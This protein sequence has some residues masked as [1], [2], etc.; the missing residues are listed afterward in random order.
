MVQFPQQPVPQVPQ[1]G[2]SAPP[3]LPTH[4]P[5][6]ANIIMQAAALRQ[7]RDLARQRMTQDNVKTMLEAIQTHQ[8]LQEKQRESIAQ[9]NI[10]QATLGMA[11]AKLEPEKALM[12]AQTEHL[13]AQSKYQKS[14][15]A[16]MN[17]NTTARQLFAL[18]QPGPNGEPPKMSLEQFAALAPRGVQKMQW[19][20]AAAQGGQQPGA[21]M[22]AGTAALAGKKTAAQYQEGAA[23]Q[24][25]VRMSNAVLPSLNTLIRLADALPR[26]DIQLLNKG[27]VAAM[28]QGGSVAAQAF[29]TQLNNFAQSYNQQF[30]GRGTDKKL[31]ADIDALNVAQSPAQFKMSALLTKADIMAKRNAVLGNVPP[32]YKTQFD[33]AMAPVPKYNSRSYLQSLDSTYSHGEA[34]QSLQVARQAG[35]IED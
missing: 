9:E 18:T 6:P 25:P 27:G 2:A 19:A 4:I 1:L 35:L 12:Q 16:M 3:R 8:S 10:A 20:S 32:D 33:D 21:D 15:A 28:K 23:V 22:M 24:G 5:D 11:Q 30:G 34:L 29:A 31:D 17:D 14:M 7:E 26:T 13:N